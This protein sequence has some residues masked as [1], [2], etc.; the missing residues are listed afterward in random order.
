MG[1]TGDLLFWMS[2]D[3][4]AMLLTQPERVM[5]HDGHTNHDMVFHKS[6][7]CR[8]HSRQWN[9]CSLFLNVK[10]PVNQQ[11]SHEYKKQ[12]QFINI[13]KGR[14]QT[15]MNR[16]KKKQPLSSYRLST[17]LSSRENAGDDNS[18]FYRDRAC[19]PTARLWGLTYRDPP[20]PCHAS[21]HWIG[22]SWSRSIRQP[23]LLPPAAVCNISI[24]LAARNRS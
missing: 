8:L 21:H 19:P 12:S 13:N 7:D 18:L 11:A 10:S 3:A 15:L 20:S 9:S 1:A 24:G 22:S 16:T 23:L 4:K 5:L 14:G 2:K 6:L 17:P